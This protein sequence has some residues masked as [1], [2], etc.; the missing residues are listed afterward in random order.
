MLSVGVYPR[1]LEYLGTVSSVHESSY[2]AEPYTTPSGL[3]T[4][5]RGVDMFE[6][7]T[8]DWECTSLRTVGTRSP[9][10]Y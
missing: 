4:I 1:R 5:G 10:A 8:W 2:R 9:K 3:E 7:G 6:S